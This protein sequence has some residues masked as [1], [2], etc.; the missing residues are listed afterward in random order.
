MAAN[1]QKRRAKFADDLDTC[2]AGAVE[3]DEH[4]IFD[5]K[6]RKVFRETKKHYRKVPRINPFTNQP[7]YKVDKAGQVTGAYMTD[8]E[9]DR[10]EEREFILVS[11]ENGGVMKQYNFRKSADEVAAEDKKRR[12]AEFEEQLYQRIEAAGGMSALDNLLS[13]TE[14]PT[15]KKKSG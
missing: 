3:T 12:R 5:G 13:L 14:E 11:L 6:R 9:V 4:F 15:P 7:F 10:E 1:V 2:P 8:L